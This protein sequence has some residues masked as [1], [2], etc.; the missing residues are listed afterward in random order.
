[1]TLD[2]TVCGGHTGNTKQ[3][4]AGGL[5]HRSRAIKAVDNLFAAH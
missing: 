3:K 4:Y 1:M 2:K 5:G